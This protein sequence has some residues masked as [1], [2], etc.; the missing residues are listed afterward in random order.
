[1]ARSFKTK[2][3]DE[4]QEFPN[5]QTQLSISEGKYKLIS[6]KNN[7]MAKVT[8]CMATKGQQPRKMVPSPTLGNKVF[9]TN[10]FMPTGGEIK[11]I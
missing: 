3:L 7:K 1:M 2:G 10:K 9:R 6:G 4:E 11:P 5:Q 8:T